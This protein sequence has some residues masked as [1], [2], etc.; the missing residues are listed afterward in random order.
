VL[1]LLKAQAAAGVNVLLVTHDE[2]L[3]AQCDDVL[4]LAGPAKA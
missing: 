3:A 1:G 4:A 2:D